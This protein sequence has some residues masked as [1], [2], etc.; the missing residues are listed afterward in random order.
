MPEDSLLD[1]LMKY[2]TSVVTVPTDDIP[3]LSAAND[4]ESLQSVV[5]QASVLMQDTTSS[6]PISLANQIHFC[7]CGI[8]L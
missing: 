7:S 3:T 8:V 2:L 5:S 6:Q 4:L 1:E